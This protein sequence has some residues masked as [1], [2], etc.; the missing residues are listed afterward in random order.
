[1]RS[2]ILLVPLAACA[3]S[4]NSI[5]VALSPSLVSSL[6][7]TTTVQAI[8]AS[9]T[10][11]RDG[12]AVQMTIDYTDRNG[13]PHVIAPV[14]GKTDDRGVFTSVV[15][16]LRWD[17]TGTITVADG[18]LA[19]SATFAV[20]DRTP[21]KVT[22]LPPTTDLHV[23][24]GLPVQ[25]QVHVTD[26]TGISEVDFAANSNV[27]VRGS[28]RRLLA[29]GTQDATVTFVVDVPQDAPGGTS[30][31]LDA[32]AADLSGNLQSATPVT[33][34]VDPAI[35]IGTP[36]G[37]SGS[38]LVDGT[39]AQLS[40][41]Q[42]IVASSKDGHLYVADRAGT[43]VCSPSCVWRVDTTTG[44][45]DPAPV[46][47]AAG[48]AQ[49][50]AV[51]ATADHLYVSDSQDRVVQLTWNGTAYATPASCDDVAQQQPQTPWHLVVDPT[52]GV[53]VVDGNTKRVEALA[54]CAVTTTGTAVSADNAF[55]QPRGIALDPA[56]DLYV[57]DMN[58]GFVGTVDR[59]TGAVTTFERALQAPFGVEW[60]AGGSSAFADSLLIADF[61]ARIV[62]SSKG[63]GVTA[64]AYL[65][66][67]PVDLALAAGTMYIV[68][69]PSAGNRGRIYQVTGF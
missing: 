42:A 48:E 24:P 27:N 9:D 43:G 11:P 12:V 10:T 5:E 14:S 46:Y 65:R 16:G 30:I 63:S 1:M 31:E 25:I 15:S 33:L 18:K 37:L 7:G 50:V 56:G 23:G 26:D 21:P 62:E 58:N 20:L 68:T 51:D 64:T 52:R 47:V 34:T 41:P 40:N 45:I 53:L 8:V 13:T 60:L 4:P 55:D 28:S 54:T 57:S 59:T 39:Q 32:L 61:D 17:G 66:N 35:T 19:G 22:I 6:D 38:L 49:G 69:A 67:N 2:L 3:G 29:T 44:A 36:P